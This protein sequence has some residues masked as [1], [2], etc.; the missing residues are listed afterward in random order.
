MF[1][2]VS[3][4]KAKAQNQDSLHHR[5]I[6]HF[7]LNYGNNPHNYEYRGIP[8][9]TGMHEEYSGLVFY[10]KP[11]E[12][13]QHYQVATRVIIPLRKELQFVSRFSVGQINYE[14]TQYR[15]TY[16]YGKQWQLG[17][18]SFLIEGKIIT[19]YGGFGKAFFLGKKKQFSIIPN[20][21]LGIDGSTYSGEQIE[22]FYWGLP[23]N[24]FALWMDQIRVGTELNLAFQYKL[25]EKLGITVSF[26]RLVYGYFKRETQASYFKLEETLNSKHI[27]Y[28][29][30]PNNVYFGVALLF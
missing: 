5:V 22:T 18:T 11:F 10:D 3:F 24:S 20:I 8:R 25:T 23:D 19:A 16:D 7:L 28:F 12:N 29:V 17:K 6:V 2:M 13:Y 30:F 9:E 27:E 1:C 21:L 14:F 15:G 4:H 26:E